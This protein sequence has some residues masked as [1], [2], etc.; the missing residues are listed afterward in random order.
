[1]STDIDGLTPVIQPFFDAQLVTE[2]GSPIKSGKEATVFACTAHPSTGHAA[3]ALKVYRPRTRRSFR[4]DTPYRDG[5]TIFRIGAGNT[6][7]ARALR[8]GSRFGRQVDS[9]TW[10][11]H[12]WEVLCRLHDAGLPVPA[13][14]HVSGDAI[15][16]E[17]FTDDDGRPA[18]PLNTARL[19]AASASWLFAALCDDVEQMLALG[20]V[21]ADLS[22]YNVLYRGDAYRIIDFP[23]AIDPRFNADAPSLLARDLDNV[24]RFCA[25]STDVPDAA[26]LAADM[27]HRFQH[28]EL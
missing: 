20:L 2:L 9:A 7:Q 12:E 17:L 10:S 28:G 26:E 3:L 24:A 27:W 25:R 6:R 13:P 21:H 22:P 11:G 1:M 5:S 8:A 16:M 14:V 19:D 23:Q 4:N 18:P 15:L